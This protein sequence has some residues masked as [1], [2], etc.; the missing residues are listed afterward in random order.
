MDV[1]SKVWPEDWYLS[2]AIKPLGNPSKILSRADAQ[3][4]L[5]SIARKNLKNVDALIFTKGVQTFVSS[6]IADDDWSVLIKELA[7]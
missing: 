7:V 1:E 4:K 3:I 5:P 6:E 2:F